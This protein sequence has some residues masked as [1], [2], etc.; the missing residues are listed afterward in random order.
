MHKLIIGLLFLSLINACGDGGENPYLL[1]NEIPANSDEVPEESI[2]PDE[3]D[4][5]T[6]GTT[7]SI[8][9]QNAAVFSSTLLNDVLDLI[10]LGDLA[11]DTMLNNFDYLKNEAPTSDLIPFN[12]DNNN[13]NSSIQIYAL[14]QSPSSGTYSISLYLGKGSSQ[15]GSADDYCELNGYLLSGTITISNIIFTEGDVYTIDSGSTSDWTITAKLLPALDI[16][17]HANSIKSIAISTDPINFEA[18][19]NNMPENTTSNAETHL[20]ISL[21]SELTLQ[22]YDPS[23]AENSSQP[24]YVNTFQK[25]LRFET[26]STPEASGSNAI[27]Y[28]ATMEASI[29]N[30]LT[31]TATLELS[32]ANTGRVFSWVEPPKDH[33]P[34]DGVLSIQDYN[35]GSS[36]TIAPSYVSAK[37]ESDEGNYIVT[38]NIVDSSIEDEENLKERIET[39]WEALLAIARTAIP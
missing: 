18:S 34:F 20:T 14:D 24:W 37:G 35:N 26:I 1:F 17:L 22:K 31:G 23:K 19:R 32:T 27:L 16:F 38:L 30:S 29:V 21:T 9:L 10:F 13:P 3:A 28:K 2:N 8:T 15:S 33:P 5:G 36:I 25:G 4:A 39:T 7:T 6:S 11:L 12:C